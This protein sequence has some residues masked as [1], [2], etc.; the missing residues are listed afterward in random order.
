[1]EFRLQR[2][3]SFMTNGSS[4]LLR[5]WGGFSSLCLLVACLTSSLHGQSQTISQGSRRI[6]IMLE[7]HAEG[8]WI[9]VEPALVFPAGNHL[10]FRIKTNFAGFLYVVNLSTE[11]KYSLLFPT[12]ETGT[13]NRIEADKEYLIPATQGGFRITGPPGH[14]IV[15]WLISPVELQQPEQFARLNYQPLPPPPEKGKLSANLIPR[16]DDQM[17]RARGECIDVTAGPQK[18]EDTSQLPGNLSGIQNLNA[19]G[20]EFSR[21][22][23]Q[24]VISTPDSGSAPIIFEFHLAHR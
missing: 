24:A 20:L 15:Y 12:E 13:E 22:Q 18:V 7:Q 4:S 23:N 3:E 19:R 6:E 5:R 2:K 9:A 21:Q 14:E 8:H 10:R 11:Q 16:C 1:M 17:F